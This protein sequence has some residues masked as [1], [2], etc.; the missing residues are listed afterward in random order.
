MIGILTFHGSHNYGS[1][2]QAY[3]TQTALKQ[4]GQ[5][6][7]IINF[8]M[9]SQKEYYSLYTAKFGFPIMAQEMVMI[10]LHM[11]RR[12]R[13]RKFEHFIHKYLVLSGE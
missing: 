1:V 5:E 11:K 10:P 7:Q 2:L 4:L 6:S 9:Q 13:G 12:E 8:R 3:A